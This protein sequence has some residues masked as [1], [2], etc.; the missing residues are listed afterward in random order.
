MAT[1]LTKKSRLVYQLKHD[2]KHS[3]LFHYKCL[4]LKMYRW[5]T[6]CLQPQLRHVCVSYNRLCATTAWA[7]RRQFAVL[8]NRNT[9]QSWNAA[10]R[11]TQTLNPPPAASSIHSIGCGYCTIG[12]DRYNTLRRCLAPLSGICLCSRSSSVSLYSH[13]GP[14]L[15]RSTRRGGYN[16]LRSQEPSKICCFIWNELFDFFLFN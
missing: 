8:L 10:S 1:F 16:D 15:N 12:Y 3:N 13:A 2:S 9:M 11:S 6:K 5:V 4:I 14:S 7:T